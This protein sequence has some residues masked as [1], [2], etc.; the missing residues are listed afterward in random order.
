MNNLMEFEEFC[1]GMWKIMHLKIKS[2]VW[3]LNYENLVKHKKVDQ[4]FRKKSFN[5]KNMILNLV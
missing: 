3:I 4:I 2:K 1:D 5:L